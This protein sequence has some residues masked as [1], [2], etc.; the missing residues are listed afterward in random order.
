MSKRNAPRPAE[1]GKLLTNLEE[2]RAAGLK[3]EN[4]K[5]SITSKYLV[6]PRRV[7]RFTRLG[8]ARSSYGVSVINPER[9]SVVVGFSVLMAAGRLARRK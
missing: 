1:P 7:H 3:K 9:M 2:S 8:Q 5:S 4:S 6:C